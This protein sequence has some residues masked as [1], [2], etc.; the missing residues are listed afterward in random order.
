MKEQINCFEYSCTAGGHVEFL[1]KVST[2]KTGKEQ[3][4][5]IN[6]SLPKK[7]S[8]WFIDIK[9]NL[10]DAEHNIIKIWIPSISGG[11]SYKQKKNRRVKLT[12]LAKL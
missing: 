7:W 5:K 3:F 4:K 10:P 8:A 9:E 12:K 1:M 11:A 2:E 6:K